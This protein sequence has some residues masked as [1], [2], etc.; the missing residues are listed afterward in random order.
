MSQDADNLRREERAVAIAKGAAHRE[1]A[2]AQAVLARDRSDARADRKRQ[3]AEVEIARGKTV[4]IGDTAIRPT[5]EQLTKGDYRDV[6]FTDKAGKVTQKALKNRGGTAVERWYQRGDL[7]RG[8]V[9]AIVLFDRAWRLR[10]ELGRHACMTWS[11][12]SGGRGGAAFEQM[13]VNQHGA[14]Q[15][16]EHL[17]NVVFFAFPL[18]YYEVWKR[19]VIEDEPTGTAGGRLG[20]TSKQAES[21]AKSIV[22]LIADMIATDLRLGEA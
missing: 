5:P 17:D 7:S 8:Q 2:R 11:L 1:A 19:V 22:L 21:A 20:F 15:L 16:L 14:K 18:R 4:N 3:S 6:E 9:E 13:L 12:T 10:Y